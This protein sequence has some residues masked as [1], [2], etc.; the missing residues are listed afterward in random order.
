[1]LTPLP[2]RF[3]LLCLVCLLLTGLE[4][5][6][7]AQEALT[8][9]H[10]E[11]ITQ[12]RRS[13]PES[14]ELADQLSRAYLEAESGFSESRV[15][16][17]MVLAAVGA[18]TAAGAARLLRPGFLP[19]E[20]VRRFVVWGAGIAAALRTLDGAQQ[21]VMF[22]RAA[23]VVL[24]YHGALPKGLNAENFAQS[25]AALPG[26]AAFGAAFITAAVAGMYVLFSVYF[27]SPA[28]KALVAAKDKQLMP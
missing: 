14:S 18:L 16:L 10:V 22:R 20:G 23:S 8:V 21:A 5:V 6:L 11:E 7:S 15:P 13:V 12:E 19:R 3:R 1:M 27:S 9:A 2:L 28:V 17:L 4:G 24:T 25:R 26:V